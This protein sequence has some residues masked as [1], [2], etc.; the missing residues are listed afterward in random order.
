MQTEDMKQD[1]GIFIDS[2]FDAEYRR[3]P[4]TLVDVGARGGVKRNWS[5]AAP[6]L[7]VLGFEPDPTE[8][9][10]L[11]QHAR[12]GGSGHEYF[13]IALH[14]QP[15]TL[16]LYLARDRG[17]SSIFEPDRS[18]LDAFPDAGRFDT[19]AVQQIQVDTL[20][21]QLRLRGIDDID[22]IKADTQGSELFV[23]QGAAHAL[24]AS[25]VGVEVEV[26]F[27]PIYKGQPVFAELDAFMRGLGYLLF[28]LKPCYWKRTAGW[29]AGGSYGQI[30]WADALYLKSVHALE[31]TLVGLRREAR[32][33]KV[34]RA[35]SIALLYGYYDYALEIDA[36]AGEDLS[37][38]ERAFI[39]HR[40]REGGE[41]H[42]PLPAFPGRR[43][44]ASAFRRLW[45]LC[46]LPNEGWSVSDAGIGNRD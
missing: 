45:K 39:A 3:H 27:T 21:N 41:R 1:A 25:A 36:S 30:V 7:R 46:R 29:K 37:E 40:L 31:Q 2:R 15:G 10:R 43:R 12:A 26:E 11:V 20:D 5:A 14:S 8:Y 28:D 19:D 4:L 35:I 42:G 13:N 33:S 34:L 24:A 32:K 6:H 44:L 17:L 18:F 16:D 38:S 22:F 23:L 9:D